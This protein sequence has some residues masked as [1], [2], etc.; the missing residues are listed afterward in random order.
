MKKKKAVPNNDGTMSLSGHLKELRNRIIICVVCL[1]VFFLLGL[2]FAPD[3]VETLT[4]IGKQYGYEFVYIAPQELLLQ[5]F[6]I[7]LIAGV[8]TSVPVILYHVWAFIQPGLK[9][10]ENKMFLA[11]LVFGLFFFILGVLFAYKIMLPFML[12]FLISLSL[13]SDVSAS[14]SVANYVTFLMTIFLVLGAVFELPVVSVLLTQ[15]GLVKVEW[16]KKFR[17]VMIVVIFF[18]AAL[19]TPPDVVSQ[20][21]VAVPMLGLYELSILICSI[22]GKRKRKAEVSEDEDTETDE[23]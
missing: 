10:N 13:G 22:L 2:H 8:V 1:V 9:K 21:M 4:G 17:K 15:I 20:V 16:M 19:I 23:E 12:Q 6:S 11:T 18:V 3:V 7:A 14:V 5:Y